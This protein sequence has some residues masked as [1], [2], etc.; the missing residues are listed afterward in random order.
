MAFVVGAVV[1]V[2]TILATGLVLVATGMRD[3]TGTQSATPI[4]VTFF[5]GTLI[6]LAIVGSHWLPRF[7]W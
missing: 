3:T 6:S 4:K 2:I 5:T 1:F 7:A